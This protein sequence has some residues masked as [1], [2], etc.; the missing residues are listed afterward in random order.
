VTLKGFQPFEQE[1]TLAAGEVFVARLAKIGVQYG[2]VRVAYQ[3]MGRVV[4]VAG[5]DVVLGGRPLGKTDKAGS[6]RYETPAKQ[7]AVEVRADG[8]L[9]TPATG[10]VPARRPAR[11]R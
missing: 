10:M 2:Q 5:A 3:A 1:A 7:T 11:S 9:P 4:P 8:Y 6:M